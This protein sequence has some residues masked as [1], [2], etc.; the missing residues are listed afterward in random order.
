MVSVVALVMVA[1]VVLALADLGSQDPSGL[2]GKLALGRV[3]VLVACVG[4]LALLQR[5]ITARQYDRAVTA[6]MILVAFEILTV[7]ATRPEAPAL[8]AVL[9]VMAVVAVYVVIPAPLI[10]QTIPALVGTVGQVV[11]WRFIGGPPDLVSTVVIVVSLLLANVFGIMGSRHAHRMSREQYVALLGEQEAREALEKALDEIRTLHGII[12]VCSH[13]RKV[14]SDQG[15]W[16]QMEAYVQ[17]HT[18]ADFSHGICPDC[19]ASDF[20]EY[21]SESEAP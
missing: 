5:P 13:C 21:L 20:P 12:P 14:R 2:S 11:M 17:R 18:D 7:T 1:V 8:N 10:V 4:L 19:M 15:S 3:L 6:W 16:E 9:A